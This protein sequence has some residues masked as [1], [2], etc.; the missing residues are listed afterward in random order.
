V[1]TDGFTIQVDDG[2]GGITTASVP[3]LIV[4]SAT[5]TAT[6]GLPYAGTGSFSGR[7]EAPFDDVEGYVLA[8]R[9]CC[10]KASIRWRPVAEHESD[11]LGSVTVDDD[12]SFTYDG[13][14]GGQSSRLAR[15]TIPSRHRLHRGQ[16]VGRGRG[17]G[18][19]ATVPNPSI[20]EIVNSASNSLQDA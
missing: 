3:V 1:Q 19:R 2:H 10:R 7:I 6:S 15:S 17:A 5:V 8:R 13:I 16:P 18:R 14:P 11:R 9:R 4:K 12:G 20:A